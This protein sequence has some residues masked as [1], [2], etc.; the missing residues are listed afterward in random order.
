MP[1]TDVAIRAAK[2]GSKVKKLSD[3]GGLQL[4]V[5][6]NGS[7]HWRLSYRF[8]GPQ[9]TM[10]LG[11][12]PDMTLLEARK[13]R[14]EA[15]KLLVSDIDPYQQKRLDK[16]TK[17]IAD[18][19]T[20]ARVSEELLDRL[21]REGK[22]DITLDK[23]RWL[24]GMAMPTIGDRPVSDITA[25]EI[26]AILKK[27]EAKDL[28]ET[29]KRLRSNIGQVF[30][31]AIATGRASIDPTS[32]LRGAIASPR[33]NHHAAI[34]DPKAFG[35]LLRAIDAYATWNPATKAGLLLMAL[36][37]PRPGELR[38]AEWDEFDFE[39]AVW[40]IPA[41]RMKMRREHRV[42]LSRQAIEVLES[43]KPLSG[44]L[45]YVF[46]AVG[47]HHRPMSENTLNAALRRLGYSAE[48]MTSHGFRGTASTLLNESGK[49]S[50]DAIER[51]LAHVDGNAVRRAYHHGQ[52]WDERVRMAQWWADHLDVLR[53]G[54]DVVAFKGKTG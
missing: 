22:A 41:V 7:K 34:T 40:A 12:Y 24:L 47:N 51:A 19:N 42:P 25:P 35:G 11:S 43:M 46:P 20:F 14:T 32:A 54:A 8:R 17:T 39:K 36:L 29:A 5:M 2:P 28:L 38:L 21:K 4:W 31:Y 52:H 3:G 53:K 30:R 13:R 1:L 27:A 45:R 16:L 33:V 15:K 49:W 9:K 6:P 37:F 48:E 23:K 10:A 44:H 18:T 26:L 50:A